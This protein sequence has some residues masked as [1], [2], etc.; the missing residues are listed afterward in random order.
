MISSFE[1]YNDEGKLVT[2]RRCL[3]LFNFM[4]RELQVIGIIF[5]PVGLAVDVSAAVITIPFV[6]GFIN[7]L[8]KMRSCINIKS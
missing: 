7:C 4:S 3:N 6:P 8:K 2:I 1:R 5:D